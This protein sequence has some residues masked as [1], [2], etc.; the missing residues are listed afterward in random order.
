VKSGARGLPPRI[1]LPIVIVAAVLLLV[2]IGY[3]LRTALGV[4][5]S[6]IG[7][8]TPA[9]QSTPAP[10]GTRE[11]GE[12][13]VPQSGGVPTPGGALPGNTVGGGGPA[14]AQQRATPRAG[15]TR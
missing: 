2:T 5:G 13:T 9:A 1:Y 4:N 10:L 6:A 12:A 11:P 15:G 14:A 3:F 8:G 7:P